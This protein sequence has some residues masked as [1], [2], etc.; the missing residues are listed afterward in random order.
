MGFSVQGLSVDAATSRA[1][2]KALPGSAFFLA[3]G[4]GPRSV[5]ALGFCQSSRFP[6]A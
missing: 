6:V 5:E 4:L 1:N 3:R 2:V